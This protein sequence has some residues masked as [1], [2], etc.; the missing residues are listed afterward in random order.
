M[1]LHK[2][3]A[4][5]DA[6]KDNA[7][8]MGEVVLMIAQADEHA[9]EVIAADLDNPEMSFDKCFAAL[10]AYAQKHQKGGFWG[11]MCNRFDPEN[12]VIRVVADFYKIKLDGAAAESEPDKQESQVLTAEPD[13]L[14][15]MDLL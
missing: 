10:R 13:A 1:S 8:Q 9:A 12:P 7:R 5:V 3:K 6:A 15:L 11:C 4:A 2:I 14:D